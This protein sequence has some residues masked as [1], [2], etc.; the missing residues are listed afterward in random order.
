MSQYQR[1]YLADSMGINPTVR[2]I[3]TFV[4]ASQAGVAGAP[5]GPNPATQIAAALGQANQALE[6]Y[7]FQPAHQKMLRQQEVDAQTY[8]D[9][10][11]NMQAFS[12]AV[13]RGEIHQ[14]D[15]PWLQMY[16]KELF[17]KD[18]A[19]E[20]SIDIAG[21]S[22]RQDLLNAEDPGAAFDAAV[23]ELQG[24]IVGDVSD[25]AY[26]QAFQR[27]SDPLVARGANQFAQGL[28]RHRV[29]TALTAL[30][31]DINN[32]LNE[33][34]AGFAGA[35][36]DAKAE[37]IRDF[38][39]AASALS[40]ESNLLTKNQVNT[41]MGRAVLTYIDGL[42]E[43]HPRTASTLLDMLDDLETSPG[44]YL[45][46]STAFSAQV[47]RLRGRIE[48]EL[49]KESDDVIK[50]D[51][52]KVY[53]K[54]RELSRELNKHLASITDYEAYRDSDEA[55]AYAASL[56]DKYG[57]DVDN[58]VAHFHNRIDSLAA[59]QYQKTSKQ[60]REDLGANTKDLLAG[61]ITP[62]QAQKWL[63]SAE[64]ISVNDVHVFQRTIDSVAAEGTDLDHNTLQ[65]MEFAIGAR[66]EEF[67][68]AFGVEV[69]GASG[70]LTM[71]RGARYDAKSN[72][73]RRDI[74]IA[75]A[76]LEN[77]ESFKSLDSNQAKSD[78]ID[79]VVDKV[80]E[81]YL[82]PDATPQQEPETRD[83]S[84]HRLEQGTTR[85][86][87]AWQRVEALRLSLKNSTRPG[88][89]AE[90]REQL[91][92]AEDI[93]KDTAAAPY[94][95]LNRTVS[96]LKESNPNSRGPN[97]R[98][99]HHNPEKIV[100]D[101]HEISTTSTEGPR[102][103]RVYLY[104]IYKKSIPPANATWE[105]AQDAAAYEKLFKAIDPAAV[106]LVDSPEWTES[107]YAAFKEIKSNPD[108]LDHVETVTYTK[109]GFTVTVDTYPYQE[110]LFHQM[111]Q[112]YGFDMTDKNGAKYQALEKS[113]GNLLMPPKPQPNP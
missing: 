19:N 48:D 90:L 36:S 45:K 105:Q 5:I 95:R 83:L 29:D 86:A 71:A 76:D 66:S 30:E 55:K 52:K 44:S 67:L 70:E 109:A 9:Q 94:D 50:D 77:S 74:Q 58:P 33:K 11:E 82:S 99:L 111:E 2:P 37:M 104:N 21:L 26:R 101:L 18:A 22:E 28:R 31:K 6:Q 112:I 64:D 89:D 20:L 46:D 73:V 110:N 24:E 4:Q 16:T 15:N 25:P 113:W 102:H 72:L 43:D 3:D 107:E 42:V 92:A 103:A 106:L 60:S 85:T 57:E 63:D 65:Q 35:D 13:K 80:Y 75:L 7:Y 23:A 34:L 51:K 39:A 41:T 14:G 1:N 54:G 38:T 59:R 78:A 62:D 91:A 8:K 40:V 96:G 27:F 98:V 97:R 81:K 56:V 84:G 88:E 17:A 79:S 93:L 108:L 12:D 49:V 69:I 68:Q 61:R 87:K 53:V 100:K 32:S 47:N 10:Y